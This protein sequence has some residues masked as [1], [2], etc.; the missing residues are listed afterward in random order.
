MEINAA[1]KIAEATPK[2]GLE[3]IFSDVYAE[4]PQHLR[5]QGQ[6]AFDLAARRGEAASGGGEFPL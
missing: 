5:K 6:A 1:T 4:V 3:T 2:P